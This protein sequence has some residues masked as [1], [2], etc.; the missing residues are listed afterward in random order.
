VSEKSDFVGTIRSNL[1]MVVVIA[2]MP[3]IALGLWQA[4]NTYQDSKLVVANRLRANA[5]GVAQDIRTPFV[6]ATHVLTFASQQPG[7]RNYGPQCSAMLQDAL[8]GAPGVT[9]FGRTDAQGKARCSAIPF[10]PGQDM[11]TSP[12]WRE[13]V[14][15]KG[16]ILAPPQFATISRQNALILVLPQWS[17]QK[18]FEGTLS[19]AISLGGLTAAIREKQ[20]NTRGEFLIVQ[21][22][23]AIVQAGPVTFDRLPAADMAQQS[24]RL[25]TATD[26]STWTY[27]AAPL[28]EDELYVVYAE[29]ER[30]VR[31]DVKSRMTFSFVMPF[32]AIAL[33]SIAI[34]LASNRLILRWLLMLHNLTGRFAKGDF[35]GE[36]DKYRTAPRE[37][38]QLAN[39]LHEMAASIHAQKTSLKT[40]LDVT[41]ALTRE[42]NHRV[43]NNLQ[44]VAS[45]LTLQ[46]ERVTDPLA[47]DA[48]E[49]AR[50]RIAA[51]GLI[52]RLLYEKDEGRE[53]GSV[54]MRDL[55]TELCGQLRGANTRRRSIQL[56]CKAEDFGLPVDQAIPLT[57]FVVE[58]IT[59]SFRHAFNQRADGEISICI[60]RK[61][62]TIHVHAKDDGSGFS[63]SEVAEGRMGMDLMRAFAQQLDGK[64]DLSSSATGT[65]TTL[66][67]PMPRTAS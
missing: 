8:R 46:S 67:L 21:R 17:A 16:L 35:T 20:G 11:R 52:H 49:Q 3:V 30:K 63:T 18:T 38:A 58:A 40:A 65:M 44:I 37:L 4:V 61:G 47:L 23:K 54:N 43:K 50:A 48:L 15:K 53:Q 29:P 64:L 25:A 22:D 26:G 12:W 7:I 55:T 57:L 13:T 27:A 31:G 2:L 9:N 36:R 10:T 56:N 62:E 41:T 39:D 28:F 45:L 42:V 33:T 32:L 51:L 59:N 1:F 34:S 6:I 24:P 60:E 5:L 19:A 14:G 66:S